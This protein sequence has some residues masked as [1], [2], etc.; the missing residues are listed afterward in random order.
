M[1]AFINDFIRNSETVN[2]T[3]QDWRETPV[4]PV[5]R[6]ALIFQLSFIVVCAAVLVDILTCGA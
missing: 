1:I 5:G 2:A 4:G 6:G 3:T